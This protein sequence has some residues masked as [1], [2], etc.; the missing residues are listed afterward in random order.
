MSH[1]GSRKNGEQ[2]H[3]ILGGTGHKR[4][5]PKWKAQP[6]STTPLEVS[7]AANCP[8]VSAQGLGNRRTRSVLLQNLNGSPFV[9]S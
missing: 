1:T 8:C 6:I 4:T 3:E 2:K 7:S 9:G 5:P